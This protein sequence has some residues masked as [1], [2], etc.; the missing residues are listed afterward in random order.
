M[1]FYQIIVNQRVRQISPEGLL[2][3][4]RNYGFQ[5]DYNMAVQIVN[6]IR[7]HPIDVF[8]DLQRNRLLAEV[9]RISS[10]DVAGQIE[11][12]FNSLIRR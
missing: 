10:P 6:L 5:I 8:D 3:L 2:D 4:G 7:S 12:L 1:G 9:A 11:D